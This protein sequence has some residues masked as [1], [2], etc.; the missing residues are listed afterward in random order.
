MRK[1][2]R[3]R[4]LTETIPKTVLITGAARRM[5][6]AMAEYL[7]AQGFAIGIHARSSMSE[8]EEFAN[9]LRQKGGEAVA[10]QADLENAASTENLMKAANSALGPI[11]ILINNASVFR[12]DAAE[13]FDSAAF[14]A[15]FAVHVRAPSILGAALVRQLPDSASG[16][17]V[18]VID[19][20][21]LALTPR[22]YS[23]TLSKSAMWTATK[24]MAQ[25]F[26]PRV[27]VN[28]I[29]PGPSFKSER[30]EPEHF[31]AQ[32]DALILKRGPQ[33]EEFGRTVRFLYDTPSITGQIIALDGGQHLSWE[34]PD[35]AE[36]P[37]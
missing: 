10:L 11:G 18:N 19:Q 26:A 23:Y 32:I 15:H 13:E 12:H 17:I 29:G 30:Q 14:D 1:T 36:I 8:A 4:A 37:E 28:A 9:E 5:G 21:V 7:A 33:P 22:F 25:S 31:Q 6:R 20:R 35:V 3:S 34:T 16:L 2:G 24:T 27:R